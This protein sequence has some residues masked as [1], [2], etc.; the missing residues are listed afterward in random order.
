M[1]RAGWIPTGLSAAGSY[2]TASRQFSLHHPLRLMGR[3]GIS[4]LRKLE[5]RAGI[6]PAHKG[7]ADL[8]NC[9]IYLIEFSWLAISSGTRV[10][11]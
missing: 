11:I 4:Y 1:T 5:A 10:R 8:L 6:E 7:F 2:D 3:C 9:H